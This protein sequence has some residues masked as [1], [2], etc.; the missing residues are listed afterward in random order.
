MH[1]NDIRSESSTQCII[2]KLKG[3]LYV[4]ADVLM[5][6][7]GLVKMSMSGYSRKDSVDM[8]FIVYNLSIFG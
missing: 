8:E 3:S 1:L 2:V 5:L 6:G 7:F 4:R